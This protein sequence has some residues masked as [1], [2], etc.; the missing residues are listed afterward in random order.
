MTVAD[1]INMEDFEN[2]VHRWFSDAT[3][4]ETIWRRQSVYQPE[5][6]FGSLLVSNGPAPAAPG[7]E[8]RYS[9]DLDRP[10]GKEIEIE[11]VM[12]CQITV[13]CQTY[14]GK[15]DAS[16]P[17]ENAINYMNKAQSALMLPSV[18]AA[19]RAENISVV[20]P[21]PVQNI[22]LLVED[23]FE[24]RANMDVVFGASLSLAE[25]TGYIA[26][27]QLESESFDMDFVVELP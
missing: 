6:P 4:L 1:P 26:K 25:L 7:W 5:Y 22:G 3:G 15:P 12:P 8:E 21:G 10:A 11:V 27:V 9:T 23:A 17:S 24:S 2:A 19:L 13:S 20:R 18:L 14:V 16:N